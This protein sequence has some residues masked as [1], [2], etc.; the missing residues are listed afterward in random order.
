MTFYNKDIVSEG[1]LQLGSKVTTA[2]ST[3]TSNNGTLTLVS[4]SNMCQF[5]TGTG[6]GYTVQLPDATTCIPGQ[7]YD[8]F[9][10]TNQS[11]SVKD[12][13][14]NLLTSPTQ[15]STTY[16]TLQS[17]ATSAGVWIVWQI[18]NGSAGGLISYQIV[19]STPFT[20]TS[21]TPVVITGLSISPIPG[22]YAV[23][24]SASWQSTIASNTQDVFIYNNGVVAADSSRNY[25]S[26]GSSKPS[27]MYTQSIIQVTGGAVDVRVDTSAATLTV[28]QRSMIMVRLGS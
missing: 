18:F 15:T 21:A 22:Q 5:L 24:V 1:L 13:A 12:A 7:R 10:E 20:T 25:Q 6:T 3:V 28:N 8:L 14:G 4:T 26:G 27:S 9:N 16:V 23:W 19:S 11:Y 17:N 2:S